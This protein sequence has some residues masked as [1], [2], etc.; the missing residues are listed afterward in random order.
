MN[1]NS[2]QKYLTD[3][4]ISE[5][6][7]P[8]YFTRVRFLPFS[9]Y[10]DFQYDT[11]FFT[12]FEDWWVRHP[13]IIKSKISAIYGKSATIFARKCTVKR[14][15]KAESDIF[16]NE[17]HI[18]GTSASKY[19]IGLYA[20]NELVAIATFAGLRN[21]ETGKSAELIR[22]CNKKF[23]TV[24]GGLSKLLS[25]YSKEICPDNIMTYNDLDWGNGDTYR[26]LGFYEC[27][28]KNRFVFYCNVHSGQRIA[29]RY[30]S[31]Y[32]N[33]NNYVSLKNSGSIKFIRNKSK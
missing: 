7:P 9:Q 15:N 29:N 28:V 4:F 19:R 31:D 14:V 27:G 30:F 13:D 11:N 1:E 26:K 18:Y 3:F 17:N 8:E 5:Q 22:Y 2:F 21:F 12:V 23:S 33:I 32:E 24:T 25:Y 10:S 20:E 6:I 16:L